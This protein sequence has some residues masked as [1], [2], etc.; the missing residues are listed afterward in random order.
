MCHSTP[1]PLFAGSAQLFCLLRANVL[2]YLLR[3]A[4]AAGGGQAAT[5]P[6]WVHADPLAVGPVIIDPVSVVVPGPEAAPGPDHPIPV[7]DPWNWPTGTPDGGADS[8][9]PD[10]GGGPVMIDDGG[11][12]WWWDSERHWTRYQ[13]APAPA[14]GPG[15]PPYTYELGTARS[16]RC[17]TRSEHGHL[18]SPGCLQP[19]LT[20]SRPHA[21]LPLP[22]S[23]PSTCRCWLT[24]SLCLTTRHS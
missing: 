1:L 14:G 15:D 12:G 13:V 18:H 8:P 10:H 17:R 11:L 16:S 9:T 5:D 23:A 21:A 2:Q 19:S 3:P 7:V 6:I 20:V 4:G 24:Q 22:Q